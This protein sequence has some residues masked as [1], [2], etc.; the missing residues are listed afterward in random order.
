MMIDMGRAGIRVRPIRAPARRDLGPGG[1]R[2]SQ[3]KRTEAL[4]SIAIYS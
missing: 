4:T 1:V 3:G 2:A